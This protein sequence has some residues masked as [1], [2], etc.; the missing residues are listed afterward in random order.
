MKNNT[1]RMG[2]V[3]RITL[4]AASFLVLSHFTTLAQ[5]PTYTNSEEYKTNA[6]YLG[7]GG[8]F[9]IR[10]QKITSRYPEINSKCLL[11][12]GGS[13]MGVFGNRILRT[14]VEAGFYYSSPT[15]SHT[16]DLIEI[17]SSINVYPLQIVS[18]TERRFEPYVSLGIGRSYNAFYGFYHLKDMTAPVNHSVTTEPYIGKSITTQATLGAG[19]EFHLENNTNFIHVFAE[20]KYSGN[21]STKNTTFLSGTSMFKQVVLN[22]G[23]IVGKKRYKNQM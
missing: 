5:T 4:P 21:L 2:K 13:G 12:E 16:I 6:I 1:P 7:F 15:F 8:S 10:A 23:F 22:I 20:G 14:K 19:L 9:G 17:S 3:I 18:K 11:Q